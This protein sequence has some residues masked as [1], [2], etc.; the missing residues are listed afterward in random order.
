MRNRGFVTNES[1]WSAN[2]CRKEQC[3]LC[4]T[5]FDSVAELQTE[6]GFCWFF[7]FF[8]Q[9]CVQIYIAAELGAVR[10]LDLAQEAARSPL[11]LLH[12][13]TSVFLGCQLQFHLT[14]F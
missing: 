3:C 5:I 9:L 13:F 8:F 11:L 7:G 2:Y 12:F 14:P 4:I 1:V 6:R 10:L